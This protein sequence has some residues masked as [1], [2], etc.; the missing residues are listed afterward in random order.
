M[1]HLFMS[2][3]LRFQIYEAQE[4]PDQLLKPNPDKPE[5]NA[6]KAPRHKEKMFIIINFVSLSL[7]GENILLD[8]SF[9]NMM[10]FP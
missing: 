3:Y 2:K 6:T 7:G 10:R 1:E 8:K 5:R 4:E 9:A